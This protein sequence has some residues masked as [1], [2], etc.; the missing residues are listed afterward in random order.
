MVFKVNGVPVKYKDHSL[1]TYYEPH[2]V[3]YRTQNTEQQQIIVVHVPVTNVER[4]R[5][6]ILNSQY[7]TFRAKY[8]PHAK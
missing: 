6:L 1:S 4:P 2:K 5:S 8:L 7:N 3:Y